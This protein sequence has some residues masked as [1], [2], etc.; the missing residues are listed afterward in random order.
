MLTGLQEIRGAKYFFSAGGAMQTGWQKIDNQWY[1]FHGKDEGR[2]ATGWV[3]GGNTWYYLRN[4]GT[5]VSNGWYA[6]D[7]VWYYFG[8]TGAMKLGK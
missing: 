7:G 5:M 3:K 8:S 1:F 4:N 2:M 6:V